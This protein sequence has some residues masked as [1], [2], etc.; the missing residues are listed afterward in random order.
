MAGQNIS[1][2][3]RR[4]ARNTVLLYFRMFLLL[5]VGLFTSR[6]ILRTLGFED[7]GIYNVV[8]SAV[9]MF[10]IVTQSL[11]TAISRFI[12]FTLGEAV[13]GKSKRVF[14][15]S[16]I[17]VAILAIVI[18]LLG[19]TLGLAYVHHWAKIPA[20]RV[21]AAVWVLHASLAVMVINR[22]S[23]PFNAEI[24]AHEHMKA[25]A[26]IS[27]V[28]ALLKL[29]V[30]IS[31]MYAPSDKLI[32][33]ALLLVL[34][35]LC[36]RGL[37]ALY[38]KRYEECKG[39]LLFDR[40]IFKEMCSFAGWNF[41]GVIP[42]VLN[43]HGVGIA[44]NQFFSL[45]VNAARN[46][47]TQVEGIVRQFVNSFTTALNPQITKSYAEGKLDYCYHL[48]CTGARYSWFLMLFFAI[49]LLFESDMLMHLWLGEY[50]IYTD[51]FAKIA[52]FAQMVDMLGSSMAVLSMATGE[53][54]RYYQIV[55]GITLA[56]LPI[57]ILCFSLGSSPAASYIVYLA[58][59]ALL[60]VAK[61]L[62]LQKQIHFPSV[63]FYKEVILRILPVSIAAIAT[64]AIVWILLPGGW[65]RLI[66]VLLVS[67]L[68][69]IAYTWL[70]GSTPG[71]REFALSYIRR[72]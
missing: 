23:V 63:R 39:K 30:A 32:T 53:V 62:V 34:V 40:S 44:T 14:S 57:S 18:I 46:Q 49:P 64:T 58:V 71:E 50:P 15:T 41:F 16:I 26:Y 69:I 22:F 3:S 43:T 21:P 13:P 1:E 12:T 6:V 70:W 42:S 47:T 7:M 11:S 51:V 4:I 48:V 28:E 36:V 59:Y 29:A 56:V 68:S 35:A 17:I 61:C 54:K 8:A 72:K 55:G 27:I 10:L 2:N 20:E 25:F 45:A 67:T 37:Y 19:E 65:L 31:L 9:T 52:I 38:C 60:I 66:L 24:V 5:I 33:Y